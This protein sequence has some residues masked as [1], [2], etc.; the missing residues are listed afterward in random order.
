MWTALES[1]QFEAGRADL[2]SKCVDKIEKLAAWMKHDRHVVIGLDGHG[3]DTTAKDSDRPEGVRR[4]AL[5]FPTELGLVERF[6]RELA[7]VAESLIG[8]A[9][10]PGG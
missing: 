3:D 2:Q 8:E 6:A 9:V 4:L 5:E 10:L 7:S 1:V